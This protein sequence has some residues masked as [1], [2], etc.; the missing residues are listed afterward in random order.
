MTAGELASLVLPYVLWPL[1]TLTVAGLWVAAALDIARHRHSE[2]F[3]N[4]KLL[5]MTALISAVAIIALAGVGATFGGQW[6]EAVSGDIPDGTRAKVQEVASPRAYLFSFGLEHA[7]DATPA[8][9]MGV[10]RDK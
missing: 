6:A 5:C 1:L 8:E 3:T 7:S 4:A 10:T 9:P 2:T